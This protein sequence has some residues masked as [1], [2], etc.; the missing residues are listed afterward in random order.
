LQPFNEDLS[1]ES[2]RLAV[3]EVRPRAK[4]EKPKPPSPNDRD[5]S[6]SPIP[7]PPAPTSDDRTIAMFRTLGFV[8]SA[9]AL[10]LLAVIAA[11]VLA[12]IAAIHGTQATLAVLVAWCLLTI[13]PIVALE[14][15]RR[16]D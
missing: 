8:L 4:A 13:G 15:R 3:E 9:R 12:I 10:L 7:D 5:F 6:L 11:F 16:G 2:D 14:W 1:P